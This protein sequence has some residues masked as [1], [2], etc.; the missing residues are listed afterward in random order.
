LRS[1]EIVIGDAA[2]SS[3]RSVRLTISESPTY[4]WFEAAR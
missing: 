3:D 2:Q 4:L 1:G